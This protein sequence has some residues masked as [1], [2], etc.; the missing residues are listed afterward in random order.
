MFDRI[1]DGFFELLKFVPALLT[2]EGSANFMLVRAML[3]LLV[4]VL[5]VYLIAIRPF[6]ATI[7]LW[8]RKL[9]DRIIRSR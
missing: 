1:I 6:R 5:I 7:G 4:I 9:S 8:M 3:G 2:E